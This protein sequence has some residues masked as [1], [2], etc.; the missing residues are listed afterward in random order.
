MLKFVQSVD[1]K[2][3]LG[4][5]VSWHQPSQ[6]LWWTDIH[7]QLLYR[8]DWQKQIVSHWALPQG[9]TAFTVLD[10]KPIKILGSFKQGFAYCWPQTGQLEWL[11]K[12]EAH[13]EGNR[14]NDGRLDRQGRFWSATMVEKDLGQPRGV[15]YRLDGSSCVPQLENLRIP[16]ALC[17]SIDSSVMY[18][19]DMPT[20]E[21][22]RYQFDPV[23]GDVGQGEHF[24]TVP[25]GEPDGAIIDSDDHL[26][27]ALWG[28]SALAR[29]SPK[30]ELTGV[31]ELPV[32]RPTCVAL[33]GPDMNLLFVTSATDG[34]S[35]QALANEPLAGSLLVYEAPFRGVAEAEAVGHG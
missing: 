10:T 9:L 16:N 27:C 19:T 30:G 5:A 20:R 18:H 15:L 33:G 21:I 2:N 1:V 11:A 34:M 28:G 8:L 13:I 14:F 3:Q 12:P 29:F 6:T 35:E 26:I 23:S 7:G 32:S 17:W 24:A 25:K 22:W 31:F 4:E